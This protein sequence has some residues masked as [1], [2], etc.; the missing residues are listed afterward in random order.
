MEEA[1]HRIPYDV[2]SNSQLS[3]VKFYGSIEV[4]GKRYSLDYVN[5]KTTGEGDDKKYFPD[6]VE[7]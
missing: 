1:K 3:V 2:W 7:E 4:N 6:L 5:C